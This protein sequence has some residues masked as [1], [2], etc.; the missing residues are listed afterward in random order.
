LGV[1]L[2]VCRVSLT[3]ACSLSTCEVMDT[4]VMRQKASD[5]KTMKNKATGML[6]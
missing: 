4:E 3:S 2:E 5:N 1:A 6:N